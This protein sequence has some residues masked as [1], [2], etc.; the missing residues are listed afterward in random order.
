MRVVDLMISLSVDDI[1]I[2]NLEE[3]F[4]F[5]VVELYLVVVFNGVFKEIIFVESVGKKKWKRGNVIEEFE[6]LLIE[7]NLSFGQLLI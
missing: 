5:I 2:L 1:V 6:F 7:N 3:K 4:D